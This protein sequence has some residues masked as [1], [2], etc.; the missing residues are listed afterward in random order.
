LV[1]WSV[2]LVYQGWCWY[3]RSEEVKWIDVDNTWLVVIESVF[4]L[5]LFLP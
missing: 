5:F 1:V 4:I 3:L 2:L